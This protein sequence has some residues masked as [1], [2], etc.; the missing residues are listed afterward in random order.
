MLMSVFT[1]AA[2]DDDVGAEDAGLT[3]PTRLRLSPPLR[4]LRFV[5]FP[6]LCAVCVGCGGGGD[7]QTGWTEGLLLTLADVHTMNTVIAWSLCLALFR[8][9]QLWL[10]SL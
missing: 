1:T 3:M 9:R 8:C 2:G 4:P 10:R 6:M 5:R 7:G